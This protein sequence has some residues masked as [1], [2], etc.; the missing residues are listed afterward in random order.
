MF[1]AKRLLRIN[2]VLARTR[3]RFTGHSQS[4]AICRRCKLTFE[5]KSTTAKSFS[6]TIRF[7]ALRFNLRSFNTVVDEKGIAKT[8]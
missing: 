5:G 1:H 7:E 6:R 4:R 3:A 8:K 2:V